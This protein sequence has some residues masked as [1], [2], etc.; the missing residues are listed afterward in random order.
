MNDLHEIQRL[1]TALQPFAR[2]YENMP[3]PMQAMLALVV[4]D[5]VRVIH[6]RD[7]WMVLQV[8]P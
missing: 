8:Q 2:A 7:A 4:F 6:L 1:R 3:P 5:E